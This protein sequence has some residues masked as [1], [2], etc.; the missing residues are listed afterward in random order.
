MLDAEEGFDDIAEG[1]HEY[2]D[3]A[4]AMGNNEDDSDQEEEDEEEEAD[5]SELGSDDLGLASDED[6]DLGLSDMEE[7]ES[8]DE[9]DPMGSQDDL[10]QSDQ[11]ADDDL[12]PY[13]LPEAT[14]SE[15][16]EMQKGMATLGQLFVCHSRASS[17]WFACLHSCCMLASASVLQNKLI[18]KVGAES[19]FI[20][21]TTLVM[22]DPFPSSASFML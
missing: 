21:G 8:A 14:D 6:D 9:D 5:A 18:L 7:A 20:Q 15:E 13:E 16:E 11:E 12:N 3:L 22:R 10:D 4:A 1:D 19:L 17:Q 2:A